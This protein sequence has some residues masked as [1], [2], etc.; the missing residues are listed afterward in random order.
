MRTLKLYSLIVLVAVSLAVPSGLAQR[1]SAPPVAAKGSTALAARG[2]DTITAAQL[3]NYLT[4][5]A[6]DEMEGRDTPSRG[7]DTTAKFIAMN[8]DRWGFKPAG[9]DGTFFQKIALRRDA[10]DSTKTTAEINGQ[11]FTFA[12]DFLPNAVPGTLSG[13]LVYVGN[14]WVIKSKN[15]N[16]YEGIDV[17]DKIIVVLGQPFPGLPRG[18]T[19]ADLSGTQGVDWINPATYAQQHGAKGVL[20]I[21]DSQT[22]QNWEQLRARALQPARATVEKFMT[23]PNAPPVPA[24]TMSM[25]MANALLEGEKYDAAMLV[26]KNEQGE[27]VPA[28]E[29]DPAKKVTVTIAIKGEHPATQNVVAVW[30]GGDPVLKNEYVAVGA[31]YD[32]VG[33]CAPGQADPICNG[34][35]DDGSGTTA[36]LGMAEAVSHAKQRPKRSVLFVWHCGEEKGLWGSRYF[37]DYPTIPLDKVV[38]QLNID[39]IGRSK[40]DGDTNARNKDLTGPNAIYV[41]GSTMMSTELGSL[42]QQVNKSFLN[43]TYDTKYDDPADPNRFFFRSDHY[44]YARKGIPIIFFFDG[45]HEDYHRPGD[46]PQKIDYDKMERVA[47]TVY[48]TLWAVANLPARPKVDKPLPAQLNRTGM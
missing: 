7:L 31:H 9:D 23:Q 21:P 17:K 14:G 47:R 35:D 46:E 26:G 25:K 33:I 22:A 44:N 20:V 32:H 41:I 36:L 11:K 6:S 34:A 3:R 45:V 43:L 28:V 40:K 30:E 16:A 18:V 13:P 15:L 48:M 1:R 37:T 39:M 42:A 10:L 24:V 29:L 4:F 19:R 38:T 8:L 27:T 12:D 2:V 5:I